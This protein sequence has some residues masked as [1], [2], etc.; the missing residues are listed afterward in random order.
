MAIAC[1]QSLQTDGAS[2]QDTE[3]KTTGIELDHTS[4][5][6]RATDDVSLVATVTPSNSTEAVTWKSNSLKVAVDKDT[7]KLTAKAV[8]SAEVTATSGEFSATCTVEVEYVPLEMES[9]LSLVMGETGTISFEVP[10]GVD[11]SRPVWGNSDSKVIDLKNDGNVATVTAMAEGSSTV[12][13]ILSNLYSATCQVTV[14]P[15]PLV[16]KDYEFFLQATMDADKADLADSGYAVDDLI[17][18]FTLSA[19]GTDAGSA[20]EAALNEEGIPCSFYSGGELKHWINHIF[21]LG[22]VNLPGGDWK[23]WIQYEGEK[24][25]DWTLGYYT[26]GGSFRLIYGITHD[27]SNME[28]VEVP[29]PIGGLVYDGTVQTGVPSGTGYTVTG[30]TSASAG[31]HTATLTPNPGYGW[32]D[33][34]SD[35][36]T[37]VWSMAP[38]VLS[39]SYAGETVD[40]GTAPSLKVTVTGFMAGDSPSNITGYVSP[41]ISDVPTSAGT[42]VLVPSGGNGGPNYTFEYV[43]GTLTI[44]L[45]GF[46]VSFLD[47]DGNVLSS[48][49]YSKGTPVSGISVPDAPGK[50]SDV[51][52]DYTFS[53]WT[54]SLA[55][56]TGDATYTAVY[57]S[58]KRSYTVTWKD[59][60]GRTIGTDTVAYGDMPSKQDPDKDSTVQ[61]DYSFRGWSP[62]LAPVT[63]DVVY[64]AVFDSLVRQYQVSFVD[65]DGKV[66]KAATSYDYGTKSSA[67][68]VPTDPQ[69]PST[70]QYEYT[71]SGWTPGLGEVVGDVTYTAVFDEVLRY[72]EITFVDEDGKK[73]KGPDSYGYGTKFSAI[74]VPADPQK[75]STAQYEYSF[76]GWSPAIA[77]VTGPSTYTATY[78][79]T[80]RSY[81]VTWTDVETVLKT[82]SVRYGEVPKYSGQ[83]PVKPSTVSETFTF[84]GWEPKITEVTGDASYNAVY[85]SDVKKYKI[86]WKQDDG[87]VIDTTTVGYGVVPTHVDPVKESIPQ[88][89]YTFK[90]WSPELFA[91]AGDAEYQATYTSAVR[92][93]AITWKQDDGTVIDTTTVRYGSTP[94][95]EAPA[96]ESD[97]Q[98]DYKFNGW[99][100]SLQTV[101]GSATYT[102]TYT[103]ELRSYTVTWEDDQGGIIDTDTV[104]YGD[105][106]TREDLVKES[107]AQYDY[108]F[109]G[110]SP[111][112]GPVKRD[113]SYRAD[114]EP[115]LRHYDITFVD[116]DG[117]TIK[118]PDSYGY[119]TKSSDISL[120]DK[121][122]KGSTA[123]YEY[124]FAGWSPAIAEVTGPSTYT[125]TYSE[126]VRSYTVTW[127]DEDGTVLETDLVAYGDRP[128][129]TGKEPSKP[130][131]DAESFAFAGWYPE[132]DLVEGPQ[133]YAATYISEKNSYVVRWLDWDGTVLK[134][135]RLM[136]GDTPS[137]KASDP[138]RKPTDDTVYAFS[139]WA[140]KVVSVT[141]NAD[142]KAQYTSSDRGY[143][144]TW[145][146]DEGTILDSD[147]LVYGAMPSHRDLKKEATAQYTFKFEGWSPA[148]AKVTG[149]V[150][151]TAV[152]SHTVNEY[153]I[154]WFGAE[155]KLLSSDTVPYG[156]KPSYQGDTPTKP[157]TDSESYLFAGWDPEVVPVVGDADYRA[158]FVSE[159]NSY[160]VTWLD[161]DGD[162]VKQEKLEYGTVPTAPAHDPV[163][164]DTVDTVYEFAG[165]DPAISEVV[166]DTEYTARYTESVRTYDITWLGP[167]GDV[168]DTDTLE[169]G[170]TPSHPGPEK[171]STAQFTYK[172]ESW[173]PEPSEVKG[174]A[175]YSPTY[176]S[177]LRSYT[178]T[179]IDDGREIGSDVLSYGSA[180]SHADPS[181]EPTVDRV[182]IFAG[183]E[184]EVTQVEG[185]VTY[186]ATY[187]ER[188]RP[189]TVTWVNEDGTVL[190][191]DTVAYGGRPSYSGATPTKPAS[192]A[193]KYVFAGWSPDIDTVSGDATYTARFIAEENSVTVR[194]LNW[195]SSVLKEEKVT[196][197]TSPSFTASEPVRPL[198]V[199]K[200][201]AFA[202]WEPEV[203]IAVSD[204]D[205]RATFTESVRTYTVTWTDGNGTVLLTEG[206]AYGA[207]PAYTGTAPTKG[208]EGGA[209]FVFAGWEP[210]VGPVVG[211]VTYDAVFDTIEEDS[212]EVRWLDWDG[213]VLESRT[214]AKGEVPTYAGT[215]S[216]V[217]PAGTTYIFAG[218]HPDVAAVVSDV[219][220]VA[221]YDMSVE[222]D[223]K[224]EVT[225]SSEEIA[226]M[227]ERG[228]S[229]SLKSEGISVEVPSKVL[230]GLSSGS[231]VF[232][233]SEADVDDLTAAQ[234]DAIGD[235]FALD[236][237]IG[238]EGRDLGGVV[239]V[240]VDY[241]AAPGTT[242][243]VYHV[244]TDGTKDKVDGSYDAANGVVTF[245]ISHCSVYAV[246]D[247]GRE[248]GSDDGGNATVYIVAGIIALVAIAAVAVV[249]LRRRP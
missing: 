246:F 169:Y 19:R 207:T 42:H 170:A 29:A 81:T 21:G 7:G 36:K 198:E 60:A 30:G 38:A 58:V 43:G 163:R 224:T 65:D 121:P 206:Y 77:E 191:K 113:V 35:A 84:S 212:Y 150:T 1:S 78:S 96:K 53:G 4:L 32:T 160:T 76:A 127:T 158:R 20:L 204:T 56:V 90:G 50:V 161:W 118:G 233:A 223:G 148:I 80:V 146:D 237:K 49:V 34:T 208:S 168:V 111:A 3:V 176:T 184:P 162:V 101:S 215:P 181:R 155:G 122:S 89:E 68:S 61:Y 64:T 218:W 10:Q 151:Y 213:T 157:S 87:T 234:R 138:V 75:P 134:Q 123:Q 15:K 40:E 220:Y 227:A 185:D 192:S 33:Y 174:N 71:F 131:T 120:P 79:E 247:E 115:V 195:D 88:Y 180:P 217:G 140:P 228:S 125:A 92:G 245:G 73:I 142:Y 105:V 201:Y 190:Q 171:E 25:N 66:I 70:A 197:G 248:Q 112:V 144:V 98:Y 22:T 97:A 124:A 83:A 143:T 2:D 106:P 235:A 11:A 59:D 93:Y 202:G 130:A 109:K 47:G 238:P 102:A 187:Q 104:K 183:W 46:I 24:Y 135:E 16:E 177:E 221:S 117:K 164:P 137:F 133:V 67:I 193:V 200:V 194:W 82:D 242:P 39:A 18:G 86:T 178:V 95:H 48:E 62:A 225:L 232:S 240:N 230:G 41:G 51:Q 156:Q 249:L 26:N 54:P 209:T 165:W 154:R 27:P 167:D 166:K 159:A 74:S 55:E 226:A 13:A 108:V 94:T 153:E 100:P 45:P 152:Y 199:D 172:F 219:S 9:S 63:G 85:S 72:Y 196:Y 149:D 132:E 23:Y 136:Y 12:T 173:S 129:Y 229:L 28:L 182:F 231:A 211:D 147:Y 119:G 175:T 210:Q 44:V 189:Y 243:V 141:G 5:T 188:P 186:T 239:T 222:A 203:S 216:R 107:T 69:K 31:T 126:T 241:K 214:Y 8:G 6:I 91:V 128:T 205:Y 145:M 110:W 236:V 37:V 52:Y 114:F 139:G 17:N 179:W 244:G 116:E 103:S 14:G 57:D 99:S